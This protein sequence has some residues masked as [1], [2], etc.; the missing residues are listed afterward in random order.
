MKIK[1]LTIIL[2]ILPSLLNAETITHCTIT[3]YQPLASQ[4][5]GNSLY[6]SDG[7]KINL[8]K[9]S[10]NSIK[11]CAVS[12]DLLYLFHKDKP[13][14]VHIEGFGIYEVHDVTNKRFNHRVD[15]LIHPKDNIRFCLNYIK[16]T[17]LK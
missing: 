17:I 3:C 6:T 10:S 1:L 13:K 7:S 9:L 11:W 4:C 15:I 2:F 12:R 8:R 14:R 5:D 16:V